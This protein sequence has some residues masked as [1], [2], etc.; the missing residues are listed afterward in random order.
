MHG[1]GKHSVHASLIN[2]EYVEVS[3]QMQLKE[4]AYRACFR[5]VD[6]E[7]EKHAHI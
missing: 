2:Y 1:A 4:L 3:K 6:G 5:V 7:R